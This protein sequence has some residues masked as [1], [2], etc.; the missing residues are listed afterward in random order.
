MDASDHFPIFFSI[1]TT[2]EKLRERVIKI[3]KEFLITVHITFFKEKLSLL[4]WRHVDFN[5]T[6]NET[7]DLLLRTMT[8]IYDANFPIREYIFIDKDIKS[9]WIS[10]GLKKTSKKIQ[11]L[12]INF[13]KTKTLE[14]QF[15][16]KAYKN[17]FEKLSKKALITYYSKFLYKYKTDSMRT[18]RVMKEI[19]GKQN[20]KIKSS[21]ARN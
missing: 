10:K 15:K 9:P 5:G 13:L 7:Y 8:H 21:S 19:T 2:K 11:N 12:Y 18:C 16:Y 6:V 1:Q 3:K 4:H 17:L 14:D 20:K